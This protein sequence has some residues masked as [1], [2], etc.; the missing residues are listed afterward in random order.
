MAEG[1]YPAGSLGILATTIPGGDEEGVAVD[2]AIYMRAVLDLDDALARRG[3]ICCEGS[4]SGRG[5]E[6]N[7]LGELHC[8]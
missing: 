4:S 1:S 2:A 7:E 6:D 8:G 3:R 5:E